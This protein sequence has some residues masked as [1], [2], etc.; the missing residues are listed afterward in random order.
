MAKYKTAKHTMVRTT[1]AKTVPKKRKPS[2]KH[3][4]VRTTKAVT[5]P[6]KH[7]MVRGVVTRKYRKRN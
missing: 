5:T 2:A 7:T 6:K 3:T 1:K 4:M